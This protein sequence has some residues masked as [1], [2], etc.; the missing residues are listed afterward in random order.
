MTELEQLVNERNVLIGIIARVNERINAQQIIRESHMRMFGFHKT[1][2]GAAI[3]IYGKIV[4]DVPY[5]VLLDLTNPTRVTLHRG[6]QE[7]TYGFEIN[8]VEEMRDLLIFANI[9]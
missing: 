9:L 1:T 6:K 3:V 8:S 2:T 7:K 4:D 5:E